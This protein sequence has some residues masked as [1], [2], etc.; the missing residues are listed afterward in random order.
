MQVWD[1]YPSCEVGFAFAKQGEGDGSVKQ[2]DWNHFASVWVAQEDPGNEF[3]AE[4][5][6]HVKEVGVDD[7][8]DLVS[9]EERLDVRTKTDLL[10]ES[11]KEKRVEG[12]H[13]VVIYKRDF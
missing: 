9:F 13:D 3:P 11:V 6:E 10:G 1:Q 2:A 5:D 4:D 8:E 7:R 12:G